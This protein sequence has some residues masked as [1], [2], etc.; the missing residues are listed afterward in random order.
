MQMNIFFEPII[1]FYSKLPFPIAITN[2]KLFVSWANK[3]AI[4]LY[5]F[6]KLPDGIITMFVG[7][8]YDMAVETLLLNEQVVLSSDLLTSKYATLQFTPMKEEDHLLGTI[9]NFI[10]APKGN[11]GFSIN[12]AQNIIDSITTE[13]RDPISIIFS[14]ASVIANKITNE[15]KDELNN[16]IESISH[17]CYKLLRT[18][19]HVTEGS[20]FISASNHFKMRNGDLGEF[21]LGLCKAATFLTKE[22]GIELTYSIPNTPVM[23]TFDAEKLTVAILNL[24]SNSC[25]FTRDDNQI[26]IKLDTQENTA[27]ITVFDKGIGIPD[28]VLGHIFE[29]NYSFDPDGKPFAGVGLGLTLVKYIICGHGGT[30]AVHSQELEG[31]TVSFSIPLGINN[32]SPDYIAQDSSSYLRN[33]YSLLYIELADVC[34]TPTF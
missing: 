21:L 3:A 25:K 7:S 10:I 14:A 22:I 8:K 27:S 12:K 5:P 9:V 28:S 20:Y 11:D 29:V 15:Q 2:D 17:N 30:V 6:L 32:N 26:F 13:F 16:Y 31:T 33:R 4:D 34:K 24:I 23:A 19:S 18:V 1:D